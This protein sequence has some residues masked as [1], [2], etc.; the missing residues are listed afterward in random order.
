MRFE[1]DCDASDAEIQGKV[2]RV[3]GQL[4][5]MIDEGLRERGWQLF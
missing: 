5:G 3:T 2:E 1:G 4:Q